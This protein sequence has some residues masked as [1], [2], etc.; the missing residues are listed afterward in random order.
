[1]TPLRSPLNRIQEQ[2]VIR[3]VVQ[4]RDGATIR[5]DS[6]PIIGG[7]TDHLEATH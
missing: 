5:E 2:A 6:E 7:I 1:M 4:A 3:P